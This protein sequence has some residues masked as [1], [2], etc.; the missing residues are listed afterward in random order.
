MWWIRERHILHEAQAIID[1]DAVEDAMH[2]LSIPRRRY[3]TKVA[4]EN[5]GVGTTL[6]EWKYQQNAA[7]PRCPHQQ[8][9]TQHIQRC[10][11]YAANTIFSRSI[12][13]LQAFLTKEATRPDLH[14]AIVQCIQ[15]WRKQQPI[16]L[17]DYQDDIQQV[18]RQQHIIGWLDFMECLPAK[19]WQILQRQYY[20]TEGIQ[21]SSRRWLRGLLLQLHHM[22][23]KQWR[24]R[25]DIK[26]NITQP[27]DRAHIDLLHTEIEQQFELGAADLPVGDQTLLSHNILHLLDKSLAYKKG[28][29]ARIWAARQRA[30]RIATHNDELVLQSKAAS[31][32]YQ[33]CLH[34]RDHPPA[35][36]RKR[37]QDQTMD[38][39][40]D[41]NSIPDQK[42][43]E[44][45]GDGDGIPV[46][47]IPTYM[48]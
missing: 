39:H 16:H 27:N 46:D 11:G 47:T 20:Q 36:K 13:S 12:D 26:N 2:H 34:H 48:Q 43:G 32:V 29:L 38:E 28:W 18:I 37:H 41:V 40:S 4:S 33:W 9:T 44:N 21:K 42:R 19:G 10:Q 7:C 30:H 3:V 35:R 15:R 6:V 1:F 5:C 31:Q 17:R 24:H 45:T 25:C 8:E 23:H 22:G 14:D